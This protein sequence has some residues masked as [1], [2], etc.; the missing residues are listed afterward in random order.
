MSFGVRKTQVI[1][2]RPP[3]KRCACGIIYKGV[4][5]FADLH[6][7][8]DDLAGFYWNCACG[9]TLFLPWR[10]TRAIGARRQA[11]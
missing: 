5:S 2:A 9:S 4:P 8:G 7:S 10:T 1:T 6:A 11:S 3:M